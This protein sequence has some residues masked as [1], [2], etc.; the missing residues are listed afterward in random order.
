LDVNPRF[1]RAAQIAAASIRR[2]GK[3]VCFMDVGNASEEDEAGSRR[4]R[5]GPDTFALLKN[6]FVH[7]GVPAEWIA[8]VTAERVKGAKRQAIADEYNLG[9]LRV[10]LGSTGTIGEGFDLQVGTT[11]LI[12]LDIP[13]DPGTFHQRVG[14][15]HRQGNDAPKLQN[16]ILLARGSFDGLTYATMRGKRGWQQQLWHSSEDRVRNSA[17]LGYDEMLA[18][19]SDDPDAARLEIE[20]KRADIE[21]ARLEQ[22]RSLGLAQFRLYV[23]TLDHQLL[24]WRKALGRKKGATAND[25]RLR[26]NFERQLERYREALRG[27]SS[28]EHSALL[29]GRPCHLT[30]VGVPLGAGSIFALELQGETQTFSVEEVGFQPHD[31]GKWVRAVTLEGGV[32]RVLHERDLESAQLIDRSAVQA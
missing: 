12:H 16:H 13:W 1:D 26:E 25:L 9:K 3:L 32:L 14:R 15:G 28:F 11:D 24:A 30:T 2:G 31:D 7:A 22:R 8:I 29:D 27:D 18:A 6:A 10:I 17:V 19:L 4:K 20:R 23:E 21:T 5:P